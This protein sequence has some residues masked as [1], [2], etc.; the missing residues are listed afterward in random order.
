MIWKWEVF[1]T[2]G[3]ILC[4][5]LTNYVFKSSIP[6]QK[7]CME[8][9]ILQ[10]VY[11]PFKAIAHV[12]GSS[13][14]QPS[15]DGVCGSIVDKSV[16]SNNETENERQGKEEQ[17]SAWPEIENVT[18]LGRWFNQG[19]RFFAGPFY[20]TVFSLDDCRSIFVGSRGHCRT[21]RIQTC[22]STLFSCISLIALI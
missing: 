15:I 19:M 5:S 11:K 13:F 20:V 22:P 8:E 21:S 7:V 6:Q 17:H 14:A 2:E 1:N 4:I 12:F 3:L 18:W 10:T 9:S 16:T